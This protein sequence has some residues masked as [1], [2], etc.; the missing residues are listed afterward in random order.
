MTLPLANIFQILASL[1][2]IAIVLGLVAYGFLHGIFRSV[3]VGM[4][5]LVSFIMALTFIPSLTALLI[6]IDIPPIYAFPVALL[7]L[8]AGTALGIH[9]I[10]QKYVPDESIELLSI[11]DK[12]GGGF[13]GGVAGFIAAGGFLVAISLLPLPEGYQLQASE[14]RFD[15]GEPMLRTFARIIEPDG[16]KRDTLL[17]GD[18]WK[19]V[20][21]DEDQVPEYPEQP[22]PPEP[23]KLPAGTTPPPF[24]P[25]P[26]NIWS[27]PFVDLNDNKQHDNAEAYLDIVKDGQFT[28]NALIAPPDD[29]DLNRFVGLLERYNTNHW[30]RWRVNQSTWESLYPPEN[31]ADTSEDTV[32][33]SKTPTD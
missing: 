19:A 24:V 5:A 28:A 26:P 23:K 6:T 32:E 11:I 8:A 12:V 20:R 18:T 33:Y 30:W 29:N 25:A 7:V 21:F 15:F 2:A 22:M 3:L 16:D 17:S 9:L 10:I 14:L 4:Q 27:E 13:V 31:Q 1:I